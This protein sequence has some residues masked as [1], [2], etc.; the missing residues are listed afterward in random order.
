MRR[1]AVAERLQHVAEL[2]LR[3]PPRRCRGPR[4]PGSAGRT[5]G[6]V[7]CRCPARRR[8]ARCRTRAPSRVPGSRS[9]ASGA[10]NGWCF[11]THFASSSL[12]SNIGNSVTHRKSHRSSGTRSEPVGHESAEAVEGD[13]DAVRRI[14]HDQH[15]VAVARPGHRRDLR[16]LVLGKEL[17]HRRRDVRAVVRHPH[18]ALRPARGR[19][20]HQ[21]RP[22]RR[23]SATPPPGAAKPLITAARLDHLRE[24]VEAAPAERLGEV[25]QLHPVA[26]VGLVGAVTAPS[27]RRTSS[28]ATAVGC[29]GRANSTTGAA[30]IAS[31]TSRRPPRRRTTSPGRAA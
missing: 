1:H 3:P 16:A 13:G 10:V 4:T 17:Q 29:R 30:N 15:E 18:Q 23:A 22:A 26:R 7:R 9:S 24:R 21:S 14:G 2:L 19:F 27:R 11:A 8:S 28:A 31:S 20:V 6:S 5:G 25:D 12:H